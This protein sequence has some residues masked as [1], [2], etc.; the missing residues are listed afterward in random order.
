MGLGGRKQDLHLEVVC[1]KCQQQGA[2]KLSVPELQFPPAI[3]QREG[4]Q[5]KWSL[6][7]PIALWGCSK[8]TQKA[9]VHPTRKEDSTCSPGHS[10]QL[11]NLTGVV[12][13]H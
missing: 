4:R 13:G 12:L 7:L 8:Q 3:T 11:S 2:G 9:L 6:V 5:A 10:K 1:F